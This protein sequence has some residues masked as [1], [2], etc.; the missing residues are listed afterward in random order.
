[1]IFCFKKMTLQIQ[2]VK[3]DNT[4]GQIVKG[5]TDHASTDGINVKHLSN[6]INI[7]MFDTHYL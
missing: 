6:I 3:S 2:E 1:M 4:V 5:Q 7:Q